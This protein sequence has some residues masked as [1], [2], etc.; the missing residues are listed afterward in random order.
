MLCAPKQTDD[1]EIVVSSEANKL[2]T[3]LVDNPKTSKQLQYACLSAEAACSTAGIHLSLIYACK[4]IFTVKNYKAFNHAV[5]TADV[6]Q[7]PM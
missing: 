4:I 2:L 5:S 6:I 7:P 1:H 3:S